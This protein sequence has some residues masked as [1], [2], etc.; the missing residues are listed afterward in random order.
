[1]TK[2]GTSRDSRKKR[3]WPFVL[4]CVLTLL[5]W[6]FGERLSLGSTGLSEV[7][8]CGSACILA[9]TLATRWR[10]PRPK[11]TL[12]LEAALS[13]ALMLVGPLLWIFVRSVSMDE[14]SLTM[15]L[16]LAPVVVAVARPAF[17][18]TEG[19]NL[20]GR[21]WPGIAAIA[22][23]LLLL[24]EPSL[25]NARRDV[26]LAAI[27]LATGLGAAW[28]RARE[29]DRLWRASMAL[30]G[31]ALAFLVAA[32]M[33]GSGHWH[34]LG[35][36]AV[37]DGALAL[38]SVLTVLRL[39]ATRWSGQFVLLPL[40]VIVEGLLILHIKMDVRY[41]VGI[42]LLLLATVFLLLPPKADD[43]GNLGL[44]EAE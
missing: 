36:P 17:R 22:G 27:P 31:A 4:L 38:L 11:A 37:L 6:T 15:T 29:G 9:L 34:G 40:A 26:L 32:V 13:G 3:W 20:A 14:A 24:P 7:V 1:M 18:P 42:A 41:A 10:V 44:Q 8:G 23:L 35:L 16:A 28:F 21:L 30:A 43:T 12:L 39:G 5:R 2:V 33:Q 25:S 19:A